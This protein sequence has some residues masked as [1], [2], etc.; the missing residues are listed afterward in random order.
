MNINIKILITA[1]LNN[2]ECQSTLSF[3]GFGS[4]D[5]RYCGRV[6]FFRGKSTPDSSEANILRQRLSAHDSS[7]QTHAQ[8]NTNTRIMSY[9][10]LCG[11]T[12]F[13]R[14]KI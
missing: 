10:H 14:I 13:L 1:S 2:V 3:S 9:M 12:K 4:D 8:T 5:S 6:R 7:V 11:L